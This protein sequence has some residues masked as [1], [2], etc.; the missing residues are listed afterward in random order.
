MENNIV[1]KVILDFSA[2]LEEN[3]Q[4]MYDK[5]SNMECRDEF[6]Q[7]DIIN[8]WFQ[9]NWEIFVE[10]ELCE[11]GKSLMPYGEGAD[12]NFDSDRVRFPEMRA[13]Y[14]IVVSS[15]G[16]SIKDSLS[17]KYSIIKEKEFDKFAGVENNLIISNSFDKVV[18][19]EEGEVYG[20]FNKNELSFKLVLIE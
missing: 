1:T 12:C 3:Y 20:M 18:L 16:K 7:L 15:S 4:Y 14:K 11:S 8:D 19:L 13:T 17:G 10:S 6:Q 2:F 5:V 9:F